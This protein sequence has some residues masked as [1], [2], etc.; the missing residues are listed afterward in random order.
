[1]G[2]IIKYSKLEKSDSDGIRLVKLDCPDCGQPLK[3]LNQ[4]FVE[5]EYCRDKRYEVQRQGLSQVEVSTATTDSRPEPGFFPWQKKEYQLHPFWTIDALVVLHERHAEGGLFGWIFGGGMGSGKFRFHIPA[6]A[7]DH[8]QRLKLAI[9]LTKK[10]PEQTL[11]PG[12][13][14]RPVLM[15]RKEAE[16]LLESVLIGAE[17]S[18]ADSLQSVAFEITIQESRIEWLWC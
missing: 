1:M 8:R 15:P 6:G 11:K 2:R 14:L 4:S 5:C 12:G 3:A 9:N 18:A 10:P 17:V 16:N 13:D 7:M